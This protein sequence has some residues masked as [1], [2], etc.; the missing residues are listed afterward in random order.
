VAHVPAQERRQQIIEAA[1]R[2]LAREGVAGA[3]TRRIAEEADANLGTLH[4]T[5]RGKDDVFDAVFNY[6][7]HVTSQIFDE[8][9]VEGAGMES[10]ALAILN[11][12]ADLVVADPDF[13]ATQYHLLTWSLTTDAG[14]RMA[15]RAYRAM[16]DIVVEALNRAKAADEPANHELAIARIIIGVIDGICLRFLVSRSEQEMRDSIAMGARLMHEAFASGLAEA[17]G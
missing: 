5:F 1:V 9:I 12:Y 2:V 4:Y 16:D 7:W 11:R 8:V 13:V 3:S 6:C 10:G 17:R 15:D 14:R